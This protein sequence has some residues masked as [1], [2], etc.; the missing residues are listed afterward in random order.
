VKLNNWLRIV[1]SGLGKLSPR[2]ATRSFEAVQMTSRASVDRHSNLTV[3]PPRTRSRH[4]DLP[5][6]Q[7]QCSTHPPIPSTTVKCPTR[8]TPPIT[9]PPYP[10][11]PQIVS[12]SPIPPYSGTYVSSSQQ[13]S[14]P[15]QQQSTP[16]P[17]PQNGIPS[18]A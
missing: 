14:S 1:A 10:S 5:T 7:H 12:P 3:L 11:P 17:A 2:I 9:T 4:L 8:S 15:T 13:I 6:H 18:I 16:A